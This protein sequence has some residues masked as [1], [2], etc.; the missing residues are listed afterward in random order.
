[1]LVPPVDDGTELV[2]MLALETRSSGVQPPVSAVRHPA[3]ITASTT[4]NEILHFQIGF[5]FFFSKVEFSPNLRLIVNSFFKSRKRIYPAPK[6]PL[7]K[8]VFLMKLKK[9]SE[10]YVLVREKIPCANCT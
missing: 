3:E 10:K 5:D 9:R 2:S 1:M 7:E 6:R 8:P 4:P